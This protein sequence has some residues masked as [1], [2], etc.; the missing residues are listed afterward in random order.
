MHSFKN[1]Y[2]CKGELRAT[3]MIHS[4]K[5][6]HDYRQRHGNFLTLKRQPQCNFKKI[7][8][9]CTLCWIV[10]LIIYL[11]TGARQKEELSWEWKRT[12]DKL[13]MSTSVVVHMYGEN[14]KVASIW[15]QVQISE[16]E[17]RSELNKE[18]RTILQSLKKTI[19]FAVPGK[20]RSCNSLASEIQVMPQTVIVF[21]SF[22]TFRTVKHATWKWWSSCHP[23]TEIH[24]FSN[25]SSLWT[26][27]LKKE[28]HY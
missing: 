26:C 4:R 17:Q 28:A 23:I 2:D 8:N 10:L 20:W 1:A 19:G 6:I 22:F 24:S 25:N 7:N 5:F 3:V 21:K 27:F 12:F 18:D 15:P 9:Q 11:K 14:K 16:I 13:M